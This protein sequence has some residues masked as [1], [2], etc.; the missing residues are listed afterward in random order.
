MDTS[1]SRTPAWL[2]L[3]Y[4][5]F[6]RHGLDDPAAHFAR[7]GYVPLPG[8]VPPLTI[9]SLR[10]EIN[11]LLLPASNRKDFV[12]ECTGN[13]PR[14]MTT[15][16]GLAI[17]ERAPAIVELYHS[18]RLKS[19]ISALIGRDLE[20]AADPV[21]RHVINMLHQGGD[22]HGYHLDDYPIALV[23]FIESPD[24]PDGCGQ[25]EFCPVDGP[26]A[27]QTASHHVGDAYVLRSDRL[28]HRV[29]PIHDGCRRTVMNFAYAVKGE[30]VVQT[31][32]AS[33][34]YT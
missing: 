17:A 18:D 5:A 8:L 11:S 24:C 29:Q 10:S 34:L 2:D 23:L 9:E 27:T 12:M 20:T 19:S 7:C 14:H 16:S 21:E 13:T 26:H 1:D 6:E 3:Q 33:L 30:P 15:V 25:L 31:A 4:E 22:T 28:R 32:S